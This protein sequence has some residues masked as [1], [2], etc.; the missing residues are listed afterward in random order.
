MI[1]S[2]MPTLVV[3]TRSRMEDV[4]APSART[5]IGPPMTAARSKRCVFTTP[6]YVAVVA[7]TITFTHPSRAQ[8]ASSRRL[9]ASMSR[10]LRA[11][12]HHRTGHVTAV[13]ARQEDDHV[14]DLP[15]FGGSAERLALRQLLEH[16]ARRHLREEWMHRQARCDRVDT[17]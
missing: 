4:A 3:P 10:A 17:H 11:D 7:R 1:A 2:M 13:V 14:G 8:R 6:L 9:H 15:W 12:G 5:T 16:V